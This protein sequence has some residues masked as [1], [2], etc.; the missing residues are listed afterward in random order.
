M[1]RAR[2]LSPLPLLSI[3]LLV[4]TPLAAQTADPGAGKVAHAVRLT[5]PGLDIDGHLT[6][7]AYATAQWLSDFTMK[8]PV[9]GQVP[10]DQTEVAF[11]YDDDALYVG[12]RLQ[13][14]RV[15]EI[16]RPVTRR[17]QFSNGE[18]FIIALDPYHDK[19][20]GYSFSVSSGGVLG[21]SYHP[22]DE[23]DNRDPAFNPVWKAS[24]AFDST[25]WYVEMRIPFSQLRFNA[26]DMQEWGLNINRWRP[27]F[28]E[29][30]YWVMIPR[31][32]A[33]FFSHFGTLVGMDNIQP[34]RAAEF[35][36]YIAAT[37]DFI[38]APGAGNP[39]NDGS[40]S[41]GRI[42]ADF[43]IGIGSNLTLD[44]TINPDFGQVES[45]PAE[46]NLS[47]FETFYPEQR[48]FFIEGNKL[49]QGNGPGYYYSRRIGGQP[50]GY[51]TG[52]IVDDADFVDTPGY[53]TILGAMKLTGRTG[54][55]MS[56][57]ALAAVTQR[58]YANLY[59]ADTQTF[60]EI[61]VEPATAY[62]V[63]RLQQELG[64]SASTVG[65]TLT[66]TSRSFSNA[67]PLSYQMVG[68]ALSGGLDG[69][70]RFKDGE[71]QVGGFAGFSY[72]DGTES[73][74]SAV[75]LS[76]A[77]YFQQPGQ[78]YLP[79]VLGQTSLAGYTIGLNAEKAGGEHWTGFL[80]T[81]AESPGFELNDLGRLST[82]DDIEGAFGINYRENTAS[83]H[84]R[85]YRVGIFTAS[86]W[87]FGGVHNYSIYRLNT[88]ATLKN[89]WNTNLGG[90]YR[91][92]GMSD[93][94]TRGGPLM[95]TGAAGGFNVGLFGNEAKATRGGTFL[96]FSWGE[97][98]A[99]SQ[100]VGVNLL[101]R[102]GSRWNFTVAPN[103]QHSINPRQYVATRD[104]GYPDTYGRRYVFASVD[105]TTL[106][107]QL[108]LNYSFTPKLTLEL[109]LEPFTSSGAYTGYGE[110]TAAQA[111]TLRAYGTDNTTIVQDPD[112]NYTVAD[113]NN[114]DVF[115]L[116]NNDF[117][118]LSYRSNAVVRWEWMPGSALFLIW[119]QN[120]N[121]FCSAGYDSGSC[122]QSG[123]T[124]GSGVAAGDLIDSRA[125]PGD[126][127]FVVKA[128]YWFSV[129]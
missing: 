96:G 76:S 27:A 5:G 80:E 121:S 112:G 3:A 100:S 77:H 87:N 75:A 45:D 91:P 7:P 71:Y 15:A 47:A 106:S 23:E 116:V 117:N 98:G 99:E 28:N 13:S 93:D 1:P 107:L 11:F 70:W 4:A 9:E 48:P 2:R 79:P 20:T 24:I 53:A 84:F 124:P 104:G 38:N 68:T 49:L 60:D 129:H 59:D 114:G 41:N 88:N 25:G 67:A 51:P 40:Q 65:L 113:G 118:V 108:R 92:E 102:P 95:G 94:L 17:D 54:S 74:I 21:E 86:G 85:R 43:K 52:G 37:A 10:A 66:G 89:W 56:V 120:R 50:Q 44:G 64:A 125:V 63:T 19:R 90:W 101:S 35:I 18:Y 110:L 126:N 72:I 36:P 30:I 16:P 111:S 122:F 105:Q 31:G 109:Y 103:W 123:V 14:S 39:F 97:F 119:Q 115:P 12:A 78:S 61:A 29:D 128:T 34:H 26:Q 127:I 69:L 42:G 32:Q 82:A 33:G 55:G 58:E 22:E 8:E 81:S 6:E 83:A 73:A 46:V 57:G 62:V